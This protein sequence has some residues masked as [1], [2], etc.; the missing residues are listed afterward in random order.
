VTVGRSSS[1]THQ[2]GA[3]AEQLALD[4]LIQQGFVLVVANLHCRW[5]EIDL[6]MQ[7]DRL[8]IFVEVRARRR[9]SFA[10][11]AESVTPAKQKKLIRTAE[12]F[13]AEYPAWAAY[14]CRFDVVAVDLSHKSLHIDWIEAAFILA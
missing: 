2:I 7:Q 13:L 5:G 12:W 4:H 1:P 8:L 3:E 6:V 10:S 14:D 9:S 11:A